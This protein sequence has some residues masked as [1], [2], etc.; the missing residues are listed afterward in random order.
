M[1]P[2]IPIN[3][4]RYSGHCEKNSMRCK[5]APAVLPNAMTKTH[6]V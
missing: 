3:P 1:M 6:L 5:K 4:I 2:G